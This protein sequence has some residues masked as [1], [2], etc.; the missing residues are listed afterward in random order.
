MDSREA[1]TNT[2]ATML[3]DMSN[4]ANIRDFSWYKGNLRWL[5][6]NTIF[7]TQSGSHSYGTNLPDSD[8]DFKGVAIPPKE[9]FLG[10]LNKFEQAETLDPIDCTIYDIR[11]FIELAADCNPN[12]IENLFVDDESIV[13]TTYS[14]DL[15]RNQR[16]LFLS[17]KAQHTFSGYAISQLKRINTHRKW[18][19]NPP[20]KQPERSDFG[21][22]NQS[23]DRE[24]LKAF[25]SRVKKYE[26]TLGGQGWSKD[27]VDEHEE[28]LVNKTANE[29]NIHQSLIPIILAERRYAVAARNWNAFLKWKTERNPKRAAMEAKFGFDGKHAMHLV[30][31]L[32]MAVEILD[33]GKV[34]VKRPDAAEL[35][36]IRNGAWTYEKLMLFVQQIEGALPLCVAVSKLPHTPDRKSIDRLLIN[37]V[38]S[39]L[40]NGNL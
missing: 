1:N 39:Y 11:K 9:Y 21:L 22:T 33:T 19:L 15:I 10:Y 20:L 4:F 12:I 30:R 14:W 38:D 16:D 29:I 13:R 8:H 34:I 36:S 32:K 25:E 35:L 23:M 3:A 28:E 2:I 40:T 7:L 37:V 31:L 26:D 5:R 24:Q 27:I 18:L 17:R 6:D